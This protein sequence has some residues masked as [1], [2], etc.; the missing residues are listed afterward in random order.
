MHSIGLVTHK[1]TKIADFLVSHL[2][3]IK[4]IVFFEHLLWL[5]FH[6]SSISSNVFSFRDTEVLFLNGFI[7]FFVIWPLFIFML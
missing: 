3:H 7:L 1:T 6:K 2:Q 4:T 5:Q